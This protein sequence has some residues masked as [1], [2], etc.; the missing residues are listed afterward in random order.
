MNCKLRISLKSVLNIILPCI[1]L[2]VSLLRFFV[3][4][5]LGGLRIDC[6]VC[7]IDSYSMRIDL[8]SVPRMLNIILPL[9]VLSLVVIPTY[10]GLYAGCQSLVCQ[11]LHHC[12]ALICLGYIENENR[13]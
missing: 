11:H 4:L 2:Y 5:N 10:G 8:K 7:C 9:Y 3:V 13:P 12:G 1:S 6:R